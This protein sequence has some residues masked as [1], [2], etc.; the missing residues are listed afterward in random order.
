MNEAGRVIEEEVQNAEQG[1]TDGADQAKPPAPK[2]QLTPLE[3]LDRDLKK[4]VEEE[5]YED[6]AKL[7]DEINRLKHTHT[8]N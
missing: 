1:E 5:R 4:A 7:R 6:A 2:K 3:S 8:E